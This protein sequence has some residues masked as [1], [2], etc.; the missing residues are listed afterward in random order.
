MIIVTYI[1]YIVGIAFGILVLAWIV[2]YFVPQNMT[3]TL[4][5]TLSTS[6]TEIFESINDL[7]TWPIWSAWSPE[8]MKGYVS[9]FSGHE[10]GGRQV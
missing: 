2:G 4:S 5:K 6:A 9:E 8:K 10:N 7:R 1:A 3:V